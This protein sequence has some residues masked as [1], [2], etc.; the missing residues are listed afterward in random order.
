MIVLDDAGSKVDIYE[1]D[2]AGGFSY[3]KS[4]D[5]SSVGTPQ[6]VT[7]NAHVV[8]VALDTGGRSAAEDP[9][10]IAVFDRATIKTASAPLFTM[11]L[12]NGY[13]PDFVAFSPDGTKLLVAIEAEPNLYAV[14]VTH[15]DEV[16]C[17]EASTT[18]RCLCPSSSP[19]HLTSPLAVTRCRRAASRS[20]RRR[21]GRRRAP[22]R[23][24][25]ST[26]ERSVRSSP[27]HS[28]RV[29]T[30]RCRRTMSCATRA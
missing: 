29:C 24:A 15:A 2:S 10:Q 9:G 6:S 4:Y 14:G 3:V 28:M 27:K 11:T 26:F 18:A 21:T 8:V 17:G 20:S 7:Y 23:R 16:R 30:R 13:L 19:K 22:T 5:V 1:I 25:S 12:T